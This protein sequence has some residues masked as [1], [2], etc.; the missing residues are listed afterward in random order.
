V[1]AQASSAGGESAGVPTGIRAGA[2]ACACAARLGLARRA[3]LVQGHAEF[4]W[5]ARPHGSLVLRERCRRLASPF[6]H[7][8]S[9]WCAEPWSRVRPRCRAHG[10]R[11]QIQ[12]LGWQ[13][14]RVRVRARPC[15]RVCYLFVVGL[16]CVRGWMDG[17][18]SGR[19]VDGCSLCVR[20]CVV[21]K[22]GVPSCPYVL[23]CRN[24]CNLRLCALSR[25]MH[26]SRTRSPQQRRMGV[27]TCG[28]AV[29]ASDCSCSKTWTRMPPTVWAR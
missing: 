13:V 21:W 25:A 15:G 19:E 11:H 17:W 12:T 1:C 6:L 27:L 23:V 3:Y 18:E 26:G 22:L 7:F 4:L 20:E 2:G 24:G 29:Q 9:A 28:A 8:L 10:L 16:V 5:S 14:A